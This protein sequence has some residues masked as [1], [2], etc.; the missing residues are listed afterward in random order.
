MKTALKIALGLSA[1]TSIATL[2]ST[3]S[4]QATATATASGTATVLAPL[5]ANKTSDLAFGTIIRPNTGSA[6]VTVDNAGARTVVGAAAV[7]G[8]ATAAS[9]QVI[10]EGGSVYSVT[11]PASF[12]MT[13]G[14]NTLAVATTNSS[15]GGGTLSGSA[16]TVST[17]SFGVGGS[18]N[19][20][21]ATAAGAYTGN[22]TITASYN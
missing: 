7:G 16:G 18:I 11:V 5:T 17:A 2:A 14:A 3:A 12:N 4:A 19:V 9:F 13:S 8:S 10:G 20:S 6:T 21:T 1:L 22:L 15:G